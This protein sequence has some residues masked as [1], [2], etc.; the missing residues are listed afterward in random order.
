[1]KKIYLTIATVMALMS[2]QAQVVETTDSR[3]L[4]RNPASPQ[5]AERLL[6]IERKQIL[7]TGTFDITP[8]LE[9]QLE[10]IAPSLQHL[11]YFYAGQRELYN[12]N[13]N[14][15]VAKESELKETR[16]KYEILASMNDPAY[17]AEAAYYLGYIDYL[18]GKYDSA[19]SYF[20]S[21]P[22]EPKYMS[23]VTFYKMQIGFLK[24]NFRATLDQCSEM[25]KQSYLYSAEQHNEIA[26]IKAE[27]LL[28]LGNKAEAKAQ[29]DKYLKEVGEPLPTSAYNMAVLEYE[30]QHYDK[31][32]QLSSYATK[33]NKHLL[34]QYAYMLMGQ[35]RLQLKQLQQARMAFEQA[36]QGA[37]KSI[38]EAAAYN[39]CAIVYDSNQSI[40]GDEVHILEDFLNSYP[41]SAHFDHVTGFLSEAYT[42]TRNYTAAL[43]SINK[44]KKPNNQ[45][46]TAKQRLLYQLGVQHYVNGEYVQANNRLEECVQMGSLNPKVL[47]DAHFWRGECRYHITD[48]KGAVNDYNRFLF[49]N[50]QDQ[51]KGLVAA[52]YYN[53]GYSYLKQ[54]NYADAISCFSHYVELPED[55]KTESYNDGVVRLADCYYYTRQFGA[56][57]EYYSKAAQ[58]GGNQADYA[59][60]QEAL[61]MG[62]QKKYAPKQEA[63]DRLITRYPQSDFV[64]DAWFDKGRTYQLVGDHQSAIGA[65]R[66]V[67]EDYPE[68]NIAP[69]AA[70]Q[71]AMTYNNLGRTDD[72]QRIYQLVSERYPGTDAAATAEEDLKT[73]SLQQRITSLP[74]LYR[75]G[76]YQQLID[77]Y[78]QLEQLNIDF[79]DRQNM[80]LLVGKSYMALEDAGKAV[81]FLQE[82]SGDMRTASGA[83]AKYLLA[84]MAFDQQKISQSQTMVNELTQSGTP[85][86]YWLARGIILMSDIY[87]VQGEEFIATEYLKSLQQNYTV[88]DDIRTLVDARLEKLTSAD[89][90]QE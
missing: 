86:Q 42:T 50:P 55:R 67:I 38:N 12:V 30:D 54:Q 74:Q 59:L 29:F 9:P 7:E 11:Q 19:L 51:Q 36:A 2:L 33:T 63:L 47:A 37:D 87:V 65:F 89:Q 14:G 53:M 17:A 71:L 84:Q 8:F 6:E 45:L 46:L 49:L 44:I 81:P 31:S 80:Q 73:L 90:T 3:W 68:S 13:S 88:N 1:M 34:R 85:H 41:S 28:E 16:R 20:N 27:C 24:G 60:Y 64:D 48:Y 35:S 61:M 4:Q 32:A 78:H 57:E 23:T 75:Q 70:V 56:A 72:A 26:R 22:A 43:K 58:E 76:E 15:N 40:W 21:L 18:E 82:A 77:T 69:Q 79:R 52:A 62:L 83:E 39:V 66:K 10:Q 5:R 25:E